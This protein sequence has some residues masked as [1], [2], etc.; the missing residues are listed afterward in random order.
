ML[1]FLKLNKD[2]IADASA[3]SPVLNRKPDNKPSESDEYD[4]LESA[5][6]DLMDA[7]KSGN[8]KDAAAALRAAFE[9]CDSEPHVEGEHIESEQD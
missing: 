1:P 3:S 9:L 4:S 5:A 6:Q 2:A 7:L 8:V